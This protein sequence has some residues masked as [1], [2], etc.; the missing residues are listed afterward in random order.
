[1]TRLLHY[2][3]KHDALAIGIFGTHAMTINPLDVYND[4]GNRALPMLYPIDISF[5]RKILCVNACGSR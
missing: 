4:D 5:S 1:M 2:E 3:G